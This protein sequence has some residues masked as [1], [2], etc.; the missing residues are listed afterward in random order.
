[1]QNLDLLKQST[2]KKHFTPSNSL[3]MTVITKLNPRMSLHPPCGLPSYIQLRR[4]SHLE[5][6]W[7]SKEAGMDNPLNLK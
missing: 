4:N 5:R 3:S 1:M 7:Y 2:L 6:P